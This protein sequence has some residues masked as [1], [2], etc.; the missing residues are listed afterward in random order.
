MNGMGSRN[1]RC[2]LNGEEGA[3]FS[4]E[5]RRE[6]RGAGDRELARRAC[7]RRAGFRG[8]CARSR[9]SWGPPSPPVST[10]D[11]FREVVVGVALVVEALDPPGRAPRSRRAPAV[12]A[13]SEAV[14]AGVVLEGAQRAYGDAAVAADREW[15]VEIK[16]VGLGVDGS[17]FRSL[18]L[19]VM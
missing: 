4:G 6:R 5:G 15:E 10:G 16:I 9:P 18:T 8:H 3:K 11:D 17:E 19:P 14:G 7:R 2:D 12:W 1:S 13:R